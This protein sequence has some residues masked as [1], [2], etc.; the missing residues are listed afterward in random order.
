MAFFLLKWVF[1]AIKRESEESD[2]RL[3]GQHYVT[4][5]ELVKQLVKNPELMN[6]LEITD[7]KEL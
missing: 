7:R 5:T 3:K 6:A 4:K 1:N 2:E